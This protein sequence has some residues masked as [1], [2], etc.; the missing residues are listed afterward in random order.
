M[1]R[2]FL[3]VMVVCLVLAGLGTQETRAQALPSV[4]LGLT[5]FMDGGPPAGP[6]Y[7]YQQ[8]AQFFSSHVF[9]DA[10]GNKL[11]YDVDVFL[12]M[13]QFIYQSDQAVLWG[14]KWGLDLLVPVVHIDGEGTVPPLRDNGGG[15]GDITF[16]PFLQW[17]PIM[18]ENGPV[19]MH[20]FEFD[21]IFPTGDYDN[22][23]ELNPGAN[24]YSLNPYW[25][26]T[27]FINPQ[28]TASTRIH[29]LY[30]FKNDDPNTRLFPGADDTQAGEAIHANFAIAYMLIADKLRVGFNG[31]FLEQI[32]DSKVD[33][34][35]MRG[36]ERVLGLGPGAVWHISQD[37]HV[38]IN[39]YFET[40][41]ENRPEGIRGQVRWTHHF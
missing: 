26:A 4:N 13:N 7:Y 38:F 17:D 34:V 14:G 11:D 28:W 35:R 3:S 16:G 6:G 37:D 25:A 22:N 5:S 41:V 12:S 8:Y 39:L 33:G 9:R 19:F 24:H 15:F 20:R 29:Y 21:V 27:W 31:Y 36:R 32:S 2:H 10:K 40:E 30:N 1:Q 23:R 18:G